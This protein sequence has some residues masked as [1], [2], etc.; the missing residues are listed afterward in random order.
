MSYT[1]RLN[2]DGIV[3]N[4]K[5]YS[6][7]PFYIGGFGLPNCTCYAWG[8]FWE[9]SDPNNQGINTPNLS[10]GDGDQWWDYN[11]DNNIY[12]YGQTPKLGAT[13]CFSESHGYGAGHVAVVEEIYPNGQTI[14][15]SNSDYGG[16]FF[17]TE[18]L[19]PDSNGKYHHQGA[20]YLYE[21][22]GFIYN[23]WAEQPEPEP[24][25]K[26]IDKFPWAVAW[27]HWDNFKI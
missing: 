12:D 1:P 16:R 4:P 23:P 8:R 17:Y 26:V 5:W 27:N 14:V 11:K 7:N 25:E 6:S 10:R 22:Q 20:V 13:I 9:I 21:S 3:G 2:A 19:I 15:T 24:E 18:T